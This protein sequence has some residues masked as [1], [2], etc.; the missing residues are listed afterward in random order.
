ML[1]EFKVLDQEEMMTQ[2]AE[3]ERSGY[4]PYEPEDDAQLNQLV[5]H[6]S[7]N[8]VVSEESNAS[9]KEQ[10]KQHNQLALALGSRYERHGYIADFDEAITHSAKAISLDDEFMDYQMN[11]GVHLRV[12]WQKTHDLQDLD[13]AIAHLEFMKKRQDLT[14]ANLVNI[15]GDLVR[16]KKARRTATNE[17][18]DSLIEHMEELY[19]L[20][21]HEYSRKAPDCL[22]LSEMYWEKYEKGGGEVVVLRKAIFYA[23]QSVKATGDSFL[24]KAM[25]L[26]SWTQKLLDSY[27]ST[28][29]G[30]LLKRAIEYEKRAESSLTYGQSQ[31]ADAYHWLG[32]LLAELYEKER[33]G[34]R[35][36]EAIKY[37]EF[38]VDSLETGDSRHGRYFADVETWKARRECT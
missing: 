25:R 3:A 15:L 32:K 5:Q 13:K 12:R 8:V 1:T 27:R 38:A 29:K 31:G 26:N 4:L 17:G 6:Y 33:D 14:R 35:I 30:I 10:A 22:I 28:K 16:L 18:P 21:W 36:K 7:Q 11:M 2:A 37:G 23:K 34:H 19:S 9:G 24:D 20:M